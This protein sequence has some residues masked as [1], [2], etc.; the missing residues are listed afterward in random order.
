M[1]TLRYVGYAAFFLVSLVLCTY[2][3]FPW[4]TVKDRLLD[5]ASKSAGAQITAESLEPSWIT[6]FTAKKVRYK[7]PDAETPLEIEEVTA[8]VKLL[9]LLGGN[10][11]FTASL[12][13]AKG[14]VEADVVQGDPETDV[15][16]TI[17][18]VE[19]ALVPGLQDAIGLP[20]GGKVDLEGKIHIDAKT[21]KNTEGEISLKCSG[22]EIL[23]GGK[24]AGFPVPELVI[25][26]FNWKVPIKEGKAKFEKQEV[27]GDNVELQIDGEMVVGSPFD[28]SQLK[29]FI[30][31]KPTDAFLKKEPI[32]NA[33]LANINRA[34]GSDGFYTYS[35]NGP[36]KHPRFT[37]Q[38]R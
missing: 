16:A 32:L 6:G 26:D 34:K 36:V 38:R 1:T 25:G 27:K 19:L 23:K 20:L 13:I 30:S 15:A 9:S 24:I 11:G 33:L 8:R 2:L 35:I 28:R 14:T 31:F 10:I 21:T 22:L 18:S 5:M 12:P 7:K 17:S 4:D 29:M 37:P 3:T